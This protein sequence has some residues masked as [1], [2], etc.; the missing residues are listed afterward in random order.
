MNQIELID[1][2]T[3]KHY[4]RIHRKSVESYLRDGKD[5]IMQACKLNPFG[6]NGHSTL[7]ANDYI[8]YDKNGFIIRIIHFE[9]LCCSYETGY[10]PSFY[11]EV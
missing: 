2:K 10:Y 4:K 1:Q 11:V 3:G 7:F 8:N 9:A 6:V 5:V